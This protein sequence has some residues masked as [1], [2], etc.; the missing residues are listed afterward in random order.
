M[1]QPSYFFLIQLFSRGL[2]ALHSEVDD[3]M[4]FPF[5]LFIRK[6]IFYVFYTMSLT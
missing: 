6:Q 5:I 4:L 1:F 2:I 3:V